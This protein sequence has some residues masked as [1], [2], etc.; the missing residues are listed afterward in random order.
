MNVRSLGY[1]TELFFHERDAVITDEGDYVVIRTPTNPGYH[2]GNMLLF[3]A[4]PAPGD[5]MRWP[6]AFE[7]EFSPYPDVRHQTFGWDSPDGEKGAIKELLD[8][9]FRDEAAVV[10]VADGPQALVPPRKL[11]RDAVIRPIESDAA[12]REVVELQTFCREPRYEEGSYRAFKEKKFA[13]YRRLVWE[14]MGQWWG[15][16]LD[17]RLVA[18]LGLFLKDGVGRFQAVETHPEARRLGLCGTLV[19]H[20]AQWGFAERGARTLVMLADESYHA[21]AIYESVGFSPRERAPGVI[22]IGPSPGSP[23]A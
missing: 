6:A 17:G 14:G 1:V 5:G 19:H 3:R 15:A 21:A 10:L 8:Q 12:W 4:P 16:Y 9:G 22:K 2:W 20:V 11:N 13:F 23:S 18:D 7:K